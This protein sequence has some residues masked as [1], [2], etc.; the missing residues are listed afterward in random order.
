MGFIWFYWMLAKNAY[1]VIDSKMD[2]AMGIT[3]VPFDS[4]DNARIFFNNYG[5]KIIN[6]ND[7]NKDTLSKSSLLLKDRLIY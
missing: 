5:G 2:G 6:Y 3:Y 1:Y 4:I 7:I